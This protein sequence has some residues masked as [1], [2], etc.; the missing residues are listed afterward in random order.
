MKQWKSSVIKIWPANCFYHCF[1]CTPWNKEHLESRPL[2]HFQLVP[3]LWFV[4]AILS[5]CEKTVAG[6]TTSNFQRP[7]Q[8][9]HYTA[10]ATLKWTVSSQ[11]LRCIFFVE[12][13]AFFCPWLCRA[14]PVFFHWELGHRAGAGA[15]VMKWQSRWLQAI[16]ESQLRH[17]LS[18]EA[19]LIQGPHSS[20]YHHRSRINT[21]GYLRL[22]WFFFT[23]WLEDVYGHSEVMT[24]RHWFSS[25]LWGCL[26]LISIQHSCWYVFLPFFNLQSW[27][28]S[29]TLSF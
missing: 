17:H 27:T 24:G 12:L 16:S 7:L 13:K 3:G 1:C 11:T 5:R 2:L 9:F 22:M 23:L 21:Q 26:L 8:G 20:V 4:V 29:H 14:N 28:D 10:T 6:P 15:H 19:H 25:D 18:A